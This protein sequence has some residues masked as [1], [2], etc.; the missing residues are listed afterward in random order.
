MRSK[1]ISLVWAAAL[2]TVILT[3]SVT[4]ADETTPSSYDPTLSPRRTSTSAEEIKRILNEDAAE[5]RYDGTVHGWRV[6]PDSV[7]EAEGLGGRDLSRSCEPTLAGAETSTQLDF[8]L[9]YFPPNMAISTVSGPRKWVC[10]DEGLSV[11]YEFGLETSLGAGT[12][13]VERSIRGRRALGLL[14]P[15]ESVEAGIINGKPAVLAHPSDDN[16]GLGIGRVIVIEDD[17]APE[18]TILRITGDNGVPFAELV[19]I[20]EA[21][22]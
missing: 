8:T 19:R 16:T 10:A 5:P 17:T 7:L 20:A 4:T 14:V 13:W 6:A 3:T 12:L 9:I 18:F 15:S 11:S 1:R 2:G 22:D 21:I